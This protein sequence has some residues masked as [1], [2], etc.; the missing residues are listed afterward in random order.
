MRTHSAGG[1]VISYYPAEARIDLSAI[2]SNLSSVREAAGEAAVLAVVKADAYGHGRA[3]VARALAPAADY[4]GAAQLG[5]ALALREEVG[6]GPRILTWIFAPGAPL[7]QALRADVELSA[8]AFWA[9]DEIARAAR[10]TGTTAK[11]HLKVDTGM[12]R[13]GFNLADVAEAS[14]RLRALQADGL[15]AVVGLWS[16]L[17]RA[18][19]PES[20]ATE[21]QI[22]RFEQARAAARSEGIEPEILHLAASGGALW[23][24]AA[25]Y[26][27]VRPGIV[28]Y[29]LS[30]NPEVATARELGLTPAMELSAS[31]ILERGVPAQTPISYGH[32]EKTEAPT[33][34]GV[35]P[36]GYGDGIPR[37]ASGVGP[38]SV[39]GV[40]TRIRGRVCM[41]Q[42]VVDVPEAA[43][44]GDT[45]FL[46][47]AGDLPSAD[48]WAQACGT[49]GY[50]IVTRLGARV[51]RRYHG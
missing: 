51:P 40:R 42:F 32:T 9:I 48:E 11:V 33:R 47:G 41:D 31:L 22:E 46:F 4:L 20:G 3:E 17:A 21:R 29:G 30:P 37:A 8:G 23:H 14:R 49:I 43:T 16:H 10:E 35:V 15:L 13:G 6:P 18:D 34:L 36:L 24:P 45:A 25:R 26:D 44:A 38:V 5:E 12:A 2:R 39:G 19:E 27:M 28:L 7:A 1:I 50:E